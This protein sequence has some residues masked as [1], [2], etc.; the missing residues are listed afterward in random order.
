MRPRAAILISLALGATVNLAAAWSLAL[1]APGPT[2]ARVRGAQITIPNTWPHPVPAH[3]GPPDFAQVRTVFGLTREHLFTGYRSGDYLSTA[4]LEVHRAGWPLRTLKWEARFD[5]QEFRVRPR[6]TLAAYWL[7]DG[8]EPPPWLPTSDGATWRRLPVRPLPAGLAANTALFAAASWAFVFGPGKL[9][10]WR[11]RRRGW[12]ERCAYPR[13]V[14]DAC[15][16]CGATLPPVHI[17]RA[18]S[19]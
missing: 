19:S 1:W 15:T 12:C 9:R 17:R 18:A 10:R 6:D 7:R 3:W 5:R 2:A 13:G 14:S 8:I 4:G 11:R 16:E